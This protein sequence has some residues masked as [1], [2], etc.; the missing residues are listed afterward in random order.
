MNSQILTSSQTPK[1]TPKTTAILPKIP[2]ISLAP[3]KATQTPK[4]TD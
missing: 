4:H 3:T 2:L 1:T